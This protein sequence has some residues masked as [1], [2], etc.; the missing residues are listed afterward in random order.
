MSIWNKVLLVF[1]GLGAI[2]FSYLAIRALKTQQYWEAEVREF[3][4]KLD[5]KLAANRKLVEAAKL[6]NGNLGTA[7][8]KRELYRVLL[9]RGRVWNN[10]AHVVNPQTGGVTLTTDMP[11]PNGISA[12]MIV[13]V[14]EEEDVQK[15]GRYL[16]EFKVEGVAEKRVALMPTRKLDADQSQRLSRSK[17]PWTL[18]EIMPIDKHETFVDM[19][20]DE[21]KGLLPK[22][23]LPEYDK[24]GKDAVAGEDPHRVDGKGKYVRL[25]RDYDAI[26]KYYYL[27]RALYADLYEAA[28]RDRQYM[29][30]TLADAKVQ[31]AFH[32]KEL[33][34]LKVDRKRALWEKQNA[35]YHLSA[36]RQKLAAIEADVVRVLEDNLNKAKEIADSQLEAARRVDERTRTIARRGLGAN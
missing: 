18:Y 36:L 5:A 11:I 35:A 17:S 31:E 34:D 20:K 10:C 7:Q 12:A 24:D 26:F 15:G 32:E 22:D 2:A 1:I 4:V 27:Q 19:E 8:A 9:G 13:Y 30:E 28:D 16:G 23:S 33:A 6:D 3:Q 29:E 21:R 14:M 25:L